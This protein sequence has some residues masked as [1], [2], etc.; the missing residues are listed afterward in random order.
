[1]YRDGFSFFLY[2]LKIYFFSDLEL[3]YETFKKTD[4]VFSDKL[5]TLRFIRLD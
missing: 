2:F 4:F 3:L 1:M 5:P